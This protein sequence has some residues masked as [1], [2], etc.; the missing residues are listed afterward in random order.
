MLS[1]LTVTTDSPSLD[2]K[3]FKDSLLKD[4][5]DSLL[6]FYLPSIPPDSSGCLAKLQKELPVMDMSLREYRITEYI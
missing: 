6:R 2:F 3:D 5:K 1:T 4:F